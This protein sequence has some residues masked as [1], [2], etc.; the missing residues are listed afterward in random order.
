MAELDTADSLRAAAKIMRAT[1]GRMEA[2]LAER[3]AS[4][5]QLVEWV[6]ADVEVFLTAMATLERELWPPK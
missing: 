1:A 4:E 6:R 2:I 3:S 5:E